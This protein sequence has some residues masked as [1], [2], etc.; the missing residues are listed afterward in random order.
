MKKIILFIVILAFVAVAWYLF[1]NKQTPAGAGRV[2]THLPWQVVI[3]EDGSTGIFGM[4]LGQSSLNDFI[5]KYSAHATTGL[6]YDP[7]GSIKIET[8]INKIRL[9]LFDASIILL[10]KVSQ[11]QLSI[12]QEAGFK[13]KP[14]PSG[15]MKMQL[16]VENVKE[17][18]SYPLQ[19]IIY[20]PTAKYQK[21][22]IR[23]RFG[24][25]D[26]IEEID[27]DMS[28]WSYSKKNIVLVHDLKEKELIYY[29]EQDRFEQSR[30]E[31]IEALKNPLISIK[32][33]AA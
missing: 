19:G 33:E 13:A 22:E 29:L 20:V 30:N 12:H 25:P 15:A 28:V 10:P 17:I 6:F 32:K 26:S 21:D 31:I 16:P 7:D 27:K 2:I 18:L 8:Y 14:G 3:A 23:A 1:N 24:E 5:D 11:E 9:G 4:V